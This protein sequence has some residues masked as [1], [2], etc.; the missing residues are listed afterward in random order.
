MNQMLSQNIQSQYWF[1]IKQLLATT[2]NG[3]VI[4]ARSLHEAA[5][6]KQTTLWKTLTFKQLAINHFGVN[7]QSECTIIS[8]GDSSDE[9]DASLETKQF[10]KNQCGVQSVRLNRCKLE[11]RS[12]CNTMMA[13]F[14]ALR[15]LMEG[16]AVD[17]CACDVM[18]SDYIQWGQRDFIEDT[19]SRHFGY[20]EQSVLIER[21]WDALQFYK[22]TDRVLILLNCH[23]LSGGDLL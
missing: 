13:Q 16:L 3:H 21:G 4:S 11:R 9:Y 23:W 19:A 12:S 8:I 20:R 14:N 5:N 18:V 10:L 2:F 6:P 1:Q 17:G 22:S 15:H 7:A